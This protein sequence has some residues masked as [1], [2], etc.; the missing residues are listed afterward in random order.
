[1]SDIEEILQFHPQ[2]LPSNHIPVEL[3]SASSDSE[4]EVGLDS[5]TLNTPATPGTPIT[6]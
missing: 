4:S 3:N 1:M 6:P 2:D 5:S